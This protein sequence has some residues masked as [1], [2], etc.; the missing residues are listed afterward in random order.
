ME[1]FYH[2]TT[3]DSAKSIF[4]DGVIKQSTTAGGR[5]DDARYGSGV[6]LTKI[7]P[8]TT[9]NRI[10]FNNYDGKNRTRIERLIATGKSYANSRSISKMT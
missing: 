9:K 7:A 3:L 2:Y 6:Y 8:T 4:I 5:R 10:A 1:T